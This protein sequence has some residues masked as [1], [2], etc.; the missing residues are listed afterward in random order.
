MKNNRQYKNPGVL[1]AG[2]KVFD[3]NGISIR[4][5]VFE[6]RRK[7]L[8]TFLGWTWGLINP[9]LQI[10]IV[11]FIMTFIAKSQIPNLPIWLLSS[12]ATWLFMQSSIIKTSNSY[13]Y[14]RGLIQNSDVEM[15][16]LVKADVLSELF[17]VIPFYLLALLFVLLSGVAKASL[18]L[19]PVLIAI[20]FMFSYGVGLLVASLTVWFRD[21]PYV[22]GLSL[23]VTFWITPIAYARLNLT[24]PLRILIDY[25]P[26]TYIL[27]LT[28]EI[29]Y[30]QEVRLHILLTA[31]AVSLVA[32]IIGN[33]FSNKS[34]R[35]A[36]I[37]L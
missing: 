27:E 4:L 19:I 34:A 15:R 37:Y 6:I 8:N 2:K 10:L 16:S 24:G 20:V 25:N 26:L 18:M 36:A 23:Q 31:C 35:K 21:L 13:V 12:M 17:V 32:L 3:Q 28:Q 7:S 5:A 9:I 1:S 33:S 22:L 29:F 30:K 11:M 14:R